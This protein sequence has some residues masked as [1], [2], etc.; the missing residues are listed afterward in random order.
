M[1]IKALRNTSASGKDIE[2][3]KTYTAPKD[4]SEADAKLLVRIRKAELVEPEASDDTGKTKGK[5]GKAAAK[6]GPAAAG[7][8]TLGDVAPAPVEPA[9]PETSPTE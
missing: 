4:L 5:G 3:G 1:K 6:T 8:P 7:D 9:P 2:K